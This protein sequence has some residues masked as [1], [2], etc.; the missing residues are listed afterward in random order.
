MHSCSTEPTSKLCQF[1]V[2]VDFIVFFS[3]SIFCCSFLIKYMPFLVFVLFDLLV[4]FKHGCQL[5]IKAIT[6]SLS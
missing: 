3:V 1:I 6:M 2:F 5:A 4:T